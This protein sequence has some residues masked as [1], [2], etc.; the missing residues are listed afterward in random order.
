MRKELFV[1]KMKEMSAAFRCETPKA[2]SLKI[3]WYY[4]KNTPDKK[5]IAACENIIKKERFFPAI[6]VFIK[7][8]QDDW[9]TAL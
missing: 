6:S 7:R 9:K 3:Y 5:F 8:T 2:E 1:E 4:L